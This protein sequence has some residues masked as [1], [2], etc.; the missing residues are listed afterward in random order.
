MILKFKQVLRMHRCAY[1]D[2]MTVLIILS[3]LFLVIIDK[4]RK[5]ITYVQVMESHH[6]SLYN[7]PDAAL[8]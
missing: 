8:S 1:L 6:E 5:V 2:I 4:L 7:G 3:N